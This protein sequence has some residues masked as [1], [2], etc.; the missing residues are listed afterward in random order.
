MFSLL[1]LTIILVHARA[2]YGPYQQSAEYDDGA[3]G[4][5][6]TECYRSN[7]VIG[8]SLNLLQDSQLCL[9][10]QYTFLA[11]AGQA[12][13]TPGPMLIDQDGHLVWTKQYGPTSTVGVYSFQGTT[14]LTFCVGKDY[15]AG[16][17]D[18]DTCYMVGRGWSALA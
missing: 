2:D 8:P 5:W 12:V 17:G 16:Y 11:P 6:P 4:E 13:D 15:V 14:H 3:F 10:G 1:V 18:A 7:P 9:D